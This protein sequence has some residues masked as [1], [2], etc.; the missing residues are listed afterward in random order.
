MPSAH[1]TRYQFWSVFWY[2]TKKKRY[3]RK[4]FREDLAAA[5]KFF[6]EKDY[7]AITLHADNHGYPPPRRITEHEHITWK[8]VR[9]GGKKYK[10]KVVDIVNLMSEYNAKGIWW[11][12]YCIKLR[13][14]DLVETMRGHEM[15]CPVCQIS[16]YESKT[17]DCNPKAII[18]EQHKRQQRTSSAQRRNR[19]RKRS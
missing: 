9:K 2:S 7:P 19:R 16:S 1:W 3:V 13:R 17:R 5:L 10:R 11:C 12:P 8:I 18:V 14:F 6:G 15:V 4:R